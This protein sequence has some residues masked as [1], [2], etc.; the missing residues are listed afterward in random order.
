MHT[1]TLVLRL[2]VELAVIVAFARAGALLFRRWGQPM[3]CGEIAAGLILGPS[4]LGGL[5]PHLFHRV[6]TTSTQQTFT[7]LSQ[8]GLVLL[9]FIVGIDFEFRHLRARAGKP[10]V[11][12]AVGI[13]IPF[14]LGFAVGELIQPHVAPTVPSGTFSLFV[15]LTLSITALPVL[16]RILIEMNLNRTPLGVIAITAAAIDDAVGWTLL[17]FVASVAASHANVGRMAVMIVETVAYAAF[18]LVLARPLLKRWAQWAM[19]RGDGRLG[20]TDLAILLVLLMLSAIVTNQIGIF[21]VFGAFLFGAVFFDEH[22]FREAVLNKLGDFV[23]VFFLP[24]FFTYTGLRTDVGSVSGLLTWAFCGL[25]VLAGI[26]GKLGGCTLAARATG[27]RWR[28]STMIGVMMNARALMALI[29][30]NV[31]LDLGVLNKT[32][33]FMLVAMA[34]VTTFMTAPLLGPLL[35][36]AEPD[37]LAH[38]PE[39]AAATTLADGQ[40]RGEPVPLSPAAAP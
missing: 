32:S 22:E 23:T 16:G 25:V 15:G 6:F 37:S 29:V 4:V 30:I 7:A 20:Q 5:F 13:A 17:A 1:E 11:V 19:R 2:L 34:V 26:V 35:A 18:L 36:R 3:V 12:S 40:W 9:L 10:V 28:D 21:A 24:I 39:P 27:L 31:G 38:V 33:F 8:L 14:G